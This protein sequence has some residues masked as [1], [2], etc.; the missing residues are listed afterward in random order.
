MSTHTT[1][2]CDQCN[3]DRDITHGDDDGHAINFGELSTY[4]GWAEFEKPY[5]DRWGDTR[6]AEY[7]ICAHCLADPEFSPGSFGKVSEWDTES[8]K[9]LEKGRKHAEAFAWAEE[10]LGSRDR[11]GY[12]GVRQ[13]FGSY[14]YG[15]EPGPRLEDGRFS[16]SDKVR[17][18][19]A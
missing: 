17:E 14:P 15:Y 1:Y 13:V 7:H 12:R 6:N 2:F 8:R 16:T 3:S 18:R 4:D 5:V 10:H 19:I 9:N 11:W